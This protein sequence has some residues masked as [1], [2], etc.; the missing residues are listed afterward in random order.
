[1]E[2]T[3]V[4]LDAM[5]SGEDVRAFQSLY[6]HIAGDLTIIIPYQ[7]LLASGGQLKSVAISYHSKE[8]MRNTP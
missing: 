7:T 8:D 4:E 3:E 1:V 6:N 5:E 2:L